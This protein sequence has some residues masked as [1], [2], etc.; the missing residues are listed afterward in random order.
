MHVV[1][2]QIV[3]FQVHARGPKSAH[4]H[5]STPFHLFN[6]SV[7]PRSNCH[8]NTKIKCLYDKCFFFSTPSV[9]FLRDEKL[10]IHVAERE[11][12][13]FW[14][15]VPAGCFCAEVPHPSGLAD[16]SQPTKAASTAALPLPFLKHAAANQIVSREPEARCSPGPIRAAGEG[17]LPFMDNSAFPLQRINPAWRRR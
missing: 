16:Q 1:S 9:M 5:K 4:G 10:L 12:S 13:E 3:I 2:H 17:T 14:S 7:F 8:F 15:Q 6:Q 11:N